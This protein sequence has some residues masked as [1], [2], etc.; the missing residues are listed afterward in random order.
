[1][2]IGRVAQQDQTLYQTERYHTATF[3]YDVPV[4]GDGWYTLVLKFSEVYFSQPSMKVY[5]F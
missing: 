2:I 5:C 1:M 4:P 3:G